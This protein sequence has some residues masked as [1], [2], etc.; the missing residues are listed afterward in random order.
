MRP[1]LSALQIPAMSAKQQKKVRVDVQSER[2]SW[3]SRTLDQCLPAQFFIQ[4]VTAVQDWRT[5]ARTAQ[6]CILLWDQ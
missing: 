1:H 4:R 5:A 6:R 3:P 2:A